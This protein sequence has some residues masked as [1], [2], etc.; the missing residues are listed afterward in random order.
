MGELEVQVAPVAALALGELLL[1]LGQLFGDALAFR[2][3]QSL[4]R[5]PQGRLPLRGSLGLVGKLAAL[6]KAGVVGE[7]HAASLFV[8]GLAA[9]NGRLAEACPAPRPSHPRSA[10]PRD[11]T[12]DAEPVV[13][14]PGGRKRDRRG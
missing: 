12:A 8:V 3:G 2:S 1:G 7:G 6:P 14:L 5:L 13:A 4:V 11:R 10:A 9:F